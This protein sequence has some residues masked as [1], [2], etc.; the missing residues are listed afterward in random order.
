[1]MDQQLERTTWTSIRPRWNGDEKYMVPM[2]TK[3][4]ELSLMS[5]VLVAC[6]SISRRKQENKDGDNVL[7]AE[8]KFFSIRPCS[9]AATNTRTHQPSA[10]GHFSILV[11][12]K[13]KRL[14]LLL[15]LETLSGLFSAFFSPSPSSAIFE[16][17][18][19]IRQSDTRVSLFLLLLHFVVSVILVFCCSLFPSVLLAVYALPNNNNNISSRIIFGL[20]PNHIQP[21]VTQKSYAY[22]V[23]AFHIQRFPI[24]SFLGLCDSHKFQKAVLVLNIPLPCYSSRIRWVSEDDA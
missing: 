15:L 1:M 19:M 16:S 14:I 3:W 6:V 22:V 23:Y 2:V 4:F 21:P 18:K 8:Q 20:Q 12:R 13:K 11:G 5:H 10:N 7:P 24:D 17:H 9:A